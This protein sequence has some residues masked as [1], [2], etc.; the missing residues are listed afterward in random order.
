MTRKEL[1]PGAHPEK[2]VR[3]ALREILERDSPSFEL[4]QGGHWG[5]LIC[6]NG[7]CQISV[8]GSPRNPQRH[9]LELVREANKCPRKDGDVRK[10]VD[11]AGGSDGASEDVGTDAA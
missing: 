6:S 3:K 7:C 1:A 11:R 8:S 5:L 2:E 4:V 9:A 10:M